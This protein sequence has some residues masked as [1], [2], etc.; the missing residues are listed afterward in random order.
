M[1]RDEAIDNAIRHQMSA[2]YQH[3]FSPST[4]R[5]PDQIR[6]MYRDD[7]KRHNDQIGAIDWGI[8]CELGKTLK[9]CIELRNSQG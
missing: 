9:T 6:Q 3:G 5:M 2:T 4:S 1:T 8:P 7:L